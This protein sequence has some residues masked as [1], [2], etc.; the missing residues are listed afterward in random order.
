MRNDVFWAVVLS[1]LLCFPPLL[2]AQ[3]PASNPN[4]SQKAQQTIARVEATKAVVGVSAV[5]LG[6]GKV[7]LDHHADDLFAP[8]S[9]MKVLTSAFALSRLGAEFKFKTT[10]YWLGNDLLVVGGFDP[11]FGDPVVAETYKK[12]IYAELDQ[13]AK[14]V[15][16]RAGGKLPGDIIVVAPGSPK[17]WRHKEWPRNQYGSWYS[18]PVCQ[19]SFNNNCLDINFAMQ[20][21]ELAPQ[22][23]PLSRLIKVASSVKPGKGG[24]SAASNPD[25]STVT[26]TGTGGAG[27]KPVSVAVNHPPL[28]LGRTLAE[29]IMQ[30]GVEFSGQV[31]HVQEA[32]MAN[33]KAFVQTTSPLALAMSRANKRSLNMT[34]ECMFLRAGDGTWD[35]SAKIAAETLQQ[36]YGLKPGSFE[37]IDGSG[38]SRGNRISPAAMT[39]LLG[40]ILAQKGSGIFTQS[41]PVS[42]VDGT[43]SKRFDEQYRGRVLGK[44]GYIA[45]VS[46]LSGYVL[47][48][49]NKPVIAYSVLVNKCVD[50]GAAKGLEEQICEMLVDY[51]DGK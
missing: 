20:G 16:D 22:L 3:A 18:A 31:R 50:L 23:S 8:A 42:G 12:T 2:L 44:T 37:V 14:A 6:S 38:Y 30:A 41:L 33:A 29:R 15:K 51:A 34:A 7:L 4:L 32:D 36:T 17:T 21:K 11:T 19:L 45:G 24:W 48:K 25:D 1:W 40:G 9:N 43:I 10:L 49:Q 28:L 35:G 46:C 5:E 39:K 26:L 47:D 13:W 27:G